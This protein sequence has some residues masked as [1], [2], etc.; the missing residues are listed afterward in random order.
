MPTLLDLENDL[1]TMEKEMRGLVGRFNTIIGQ[2]SVKIIKENFDLQGYDDGVSFKVWAERSE[3]TNNWYDS[4]VSANR[5]GKSV[6]YKSTNPILTQ[7]KNLKIDSLQ[8]RA[9]KGEVDVGVYRS[10][11]M[12][13]GEPHDAVEYGQENNEGTSI[14]PQRQFMPMPDEGANEKMAAN[15]LGRWKWEEQKIMSKFK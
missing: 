8:Y 2:E 15:F 1:S 14:V 11:V 9:R 5:K 3:V 6:L 7:S 13:N 12:L 4:G 10:V